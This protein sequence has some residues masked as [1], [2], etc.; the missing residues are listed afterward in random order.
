MTSKREWRV[1]QFMKALKASLETCALKFTI[2]NQYCCDQRD[3]DVSF[4]CK[5]NEPS[6]KNQ[7]KI[8]M[9]R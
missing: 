4:I 6:N 9:P 3:I 8:L 7:R 2:D 1:L 5:M